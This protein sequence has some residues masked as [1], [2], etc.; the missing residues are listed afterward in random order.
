M[1]R[2][3]LKST[4]GF[5]LVEISIAAFLVLMLLFVMGLLLQ[6]YRLTCFSAMRTDAAIVAQAKLEQLA[7]GIITATG[8]ETI[9]VNHARYVV[10]WDKSLLDETGKNQLYKATVTVTWTENSLSK[11]KMFSTYLLAATNYQVRPQW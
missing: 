3:V 4:K 6:A 1:N 7:A 9:A 10:I 11:S 8:Q 5:L 2:I